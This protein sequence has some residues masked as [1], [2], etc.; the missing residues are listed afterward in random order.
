MADCH[1]GAWR[2]PRMRTANAQAFIQGMGRAL[3]EDVDFIIISGDLFNTAIPGIDSIRIAVEQLKLAQDKGIPVYGIPGSH[4]FSPSGKTMLDVLE[5]AGLFINVAKGESVEGK[6][7]LRFTRD[8]KTGALLTGIFG[9]QGG[10]D[11]YYY[12]DLMRDHL[13]VDGFKI[14]C[15]HCGLAELK[16]K[17]LEKMEVMSANLLPVNFNYYA[18]GHIH[19]VDHAKLENHPNIIFPGPTFPNN[20]AEIEKLDGGN[21]CIYDNGEIRDVLLA[22]YPLVNHII[23]CDGKTPVQVEAT[24]QEVAEA[25]GYDNAIVTIRYKGLLC[26]GTSSQINFMRLAELFSSAYFVMRNTAA[27]RSKQYEEIQVS[28]ESIDTVERRVISEHVGQSGLYDAKIEEQ[29]INSLLHV[30][31]QEKNE[32]M[33]KSDFEQHIIREVRSTLDLQ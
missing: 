25:G 21:M 14:F 31:G 20:F 7:K 10:L 3:E 29:I 23:D 12:E 30:L 22:P 16:P 28:T 2:D 32:A 33:K 1:L 15:F 18:G 5:G 26:E 11:K 19:V 27:L 4:D 9:R 24:V 8:E 6:L 17:G 13:Q